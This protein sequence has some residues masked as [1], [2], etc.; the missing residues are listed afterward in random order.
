M[1]LAPTSSALLADAVLILHVG[2]AAFVVGGLV[3]TIL[4][5]LRRWTWVN[6]L[7]FRLAHL[8]A[9]AVVVAE[10][11][12][13][14]ACPLTTLEMALR[15]NVGAATYDGGF[16]AHWLQRLLYFE[17]PPWVFVAGYTVFGG[18]VLAT[19]WLY[20]PVFCSGRRERGC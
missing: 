9:I 2:I 6:R 8:A 7:G 13:G 18:L 16:V 14:L 4:G 12:F 3:L 17:A 15:S 5:N 19:W 1:T 11:W 20:P 10:S